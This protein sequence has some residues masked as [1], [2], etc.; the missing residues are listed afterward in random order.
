MGDCTYHYS[1]DGHSLTL[2]HQGDVQLELARTPLNQKLIRQ[3]PA[4][5]VIRALY[6]RTLGRY[7]DRE[8]SYVRM[9]VRQARQN[10]YLQ[11]TAI[12]LATAATDAFHDEQAR[13]AL[14]LNKRCKPLYIMPVD[15]PRA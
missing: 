15:R 11:T 5:I 13:E 7:G 12:N 14:R 8:D 6:E 4:D 10:I 3:A 2:G 1:V 9:E